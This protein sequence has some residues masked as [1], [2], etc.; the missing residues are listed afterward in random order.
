MNNEFRR[1]FNS[2]FI[3]E[4]SK[5]TRLLSI[6]DNRLKKTSEDISVGFE[7]S[8]EKGKSIKTRSIDEVFK[9]D[10]PIN[11][12]LIDFEITYIDK[13]GKNMCSINYDREDSRIRVYVST[14][15]AKEGNDLFAEIEEQIERSIVNS[16]V[17]NLKKQTSFDTFLFLPIIFAMLFVLLIESNSTSENIKKTDYLKKEDIEFL[18]KYSESKGITTD[19]KIDFFYEYQLRRIKNINHK[20][21]NVFEGFSMEKFFNIKFL[22]LGLPVLIILGCLYYIFSKTYIG[23]IFLWGDYEDYY[24]SFIERRKFLWS[25]VVVS[26]ILGVI[27]NLF[28]F[29]F[30]QYI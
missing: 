18:L 6:I 3:L 20:K 22:I 17:Y 30:S 27:S 10:N 19:K 26:L 16:W 12:S 1:T 14:E 2:V 11:N 13:D 28:V 4:P 21:S 23:S 29:G 7:V 9:Q 8:T 15:D 5:L 25:T 24:K